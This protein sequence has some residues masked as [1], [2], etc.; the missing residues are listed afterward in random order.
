VGLIGCSCSCCRCESDIGFFL[1]LID[2]CVVP[3]WVMEAN[4]NKNSLQKCVKDKW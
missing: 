2:R 3:N 1:S 4:K